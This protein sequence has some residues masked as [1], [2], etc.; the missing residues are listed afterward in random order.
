[1]SPRGVSQN[2]KMRADALAKISSAALNVFSEYGYHGATMKQIAQASGLSYGLIYH[3]FPSKERVFR[4]LVDFALESTIAGMHAFLD[5]PGAAWEKIERYSAILIQTALTGE[6][7]Q[8]FLIM[9][10]AMTQGKAIPGLLDHIQKRSTVYFEMMAPIIAE[11]Q[12]T[13]EAAQGDPLVLATAFFSLLQGLSLFMFH[14]K[15]FEKNIT[16]EILI[17]VL[18]NGVSPP[19]R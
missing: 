6:S 12:K 9:L 11:A 5:G 7:S 10:Q 2:E 17:S 3:Y 16:P 1:M 8:Y 18:R 13:G 14:R 4:H 15:G 19:E